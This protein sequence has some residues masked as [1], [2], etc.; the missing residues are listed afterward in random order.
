VTDAAADARASATAAAGSA[1][2]AAT[3]ASE[4]ADSANQA[5][6][7]AT[8]AA[9]SSSQASSSAASAS[10]SATAASTSETN[11]ANSATAAAGSASAA[12][13]SEQNAS[14]SATAA[15]TAQ[16]A[17]ED[18]QDAAETA[19]ASVSAS[20]AQIAQNTS[21]VADLSRQLSDLEDTVSTTQIINTAS[22][23]IASFDDGADGQP[24]RKLVANIEPVQDLHG[25]SNPW[26]AG[27]GANKFDLSA[28]ATFN[29]NVTV[30]KTDD[31][32]TVTNN[33]SYDVNA[34]RASGYDMYW[35]LA[36][37]QY[38]ISIGSAITTD[39]SVYASADGTSYAW[40]D[41]GI[42]AGATQKTFTVTAEKPYITVRAMVRSGSSM[43]ITK[44]QLELGS[45][46]TAYSPYENLC[47][48]SGHTGA[49]IEQTGKNL[50]AKP[51]VLF[52]TDTPISDC[53]FMRAG[54]YVLTCDCLNTFRIGFRLLSPDGALITNADY[55]PATN[56]IYNASAKAFYAP[57]DLP[58]GHRTTSFTLVSDCYVRI[59]K[60]N[61]DVTNVMI[62]L[63]SDTEAYEPYTG[64]QISIDWSDE[65][66]TIYGGEHDVISGKLKKTMER[67]DLGILNWTM[68]DHN[69]FGRYFYADIISLNIKHEG[70]NFVDAY[71]AIC[72]QYKVVGRNQTE[73]TDYTCCLDGSSTKVTQLQIKDSKYDNASSFKSAISGVKFCYK[74]AEPFEYTLTGNEM[75]TI[76]GT[77]NI[78]SSTGATEVNYSADT[79]IYIDRKI[80]EALGG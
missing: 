11:A 42:V 34:F 40:S 12:A 21:D 39:I 74:I 22:G 10:A 28:I 70:G 31:S 30:T 72:S 14:N 8:S 1:T 2:N 44:F 80:A 49:E 5:S 24:I 17:A 45:A 15:Q 47:P 60:N 55:A 51:I 6:S 64:N 19:A 32:F 41:N 54:D 52:S 29:A 61:N 38:S 27:G 53:F 25:Y 59:V 4:A 56:W 76:Y 66:G 9:T 33:N 65:A 50:L 13:T 36:P 68:V 46:A 43:T 23:A 78:W 62:R 37:G 26:P 67:V 48:I 75:E 73:F 71:P 18:A 77:N 58:S 69:T 20:V 57:V 79:K 63:P 3:S 35:V 16:S 7:F